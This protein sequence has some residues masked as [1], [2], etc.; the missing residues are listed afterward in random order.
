MD[1]Q[2]NTQAATPTHSA[3]PELKQPPV[4][5]V[6]TIA[7]SNSYLPPQPVPTAPPTVP[8]QPVQPIQSRQQGQSEQHPE[9]PSAPPVSYAPSQS[10]PQSVQY[11][12]PI[13]S[14]PSVQPMQQPVQYMAQTHPPPAH[15]VQQLVSY[16][17]AQPMQQM[18][19][20]QQQ[21]PM[22]C[23]QVSVTYPAPMQPMQSMHG[24]YQ[25]SA[26]Q[27]V[28]SLPAGHHYPAMA[29]QTHPM[30]T[31]SFPPNS[32][33]QLRPVPKGPVIRTQP[34]P[35]LPAIFETKISHE[36]GNCTWIAF[37]L[38]F[39]TAALTLCSPC[40]FCIVQWQDVN[41][42]CPHCNHPV[43]SYKR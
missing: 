9:A 22:P 20:V 39:W 40:A 23:C 35:S 1:G 29:Q 2:D 27:P 41:H 26:S 43:G 15:P 19:S 17:M 14:P 7:A 6:A 36:I 16:R 4:A 25:I 13:Q 3:S 12:A 21:M 33:P 28:H 37:C 38:C 8:Q 10:V 24:G 11:V 5:P 31:G 18:A 32:Q 34:E 42:Y 30:N